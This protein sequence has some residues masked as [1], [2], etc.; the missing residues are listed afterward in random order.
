MELEGGRVTWALLNCR[1]F[2]LHWKTT[3]TQHQHDEQGVDR[4]KPKKKHR[5]SGLKET[6]NR[7]KKKKIRT[8]ENKKK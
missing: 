3:N 1:W 7:T 6:A 8:I 4:K 2:E 5:L